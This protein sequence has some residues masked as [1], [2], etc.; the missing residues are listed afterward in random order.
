MSRGNISLDDIRELSFYIQSANRSI[1]NADRELSRSKSKSRTMMKSF[2][3][4]NED[5]T[6]ISSLETN[7]FVR[8]VITV[9]TK[10]KNSV[11]NVTSPSSNLSKATE[12]TE[13]VKK[14]KKNNQ[15][16]KKP[17]KLLY[18]KFQIPSSTAKPKK[19][20]SRN[21]YNT[22]FN[23][24]Y[25]S[26]INSN[27]TNHQKTYSSINHF[28]DKDIKE[29]KCITK[30]NITDT[31]RKEKKINFAQVMNYKGI[32]QTDNK[33]LYEMFMVLNR[34]TVPNAN[35]KELNNNEIKETHKIKLIQREW[36]KHYIRTKMINK[37]DKANTSNILLLSKMEFFNYLVNNDKNFKELIHTMNKANELYQ[38]CLKNKTFC[39]MKNVI[40]S[41]KMF[42]I[43]NTHLRI[44]KR[45]I[46][47][48][49]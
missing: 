23:N 48:K 33:E 16:K 24:T 14:I 12:E 35:I 18:E 15:M 39:D 36:R 21:L 1:E 46:V 44:N 34:L 13:Y 11:L 3:V 41:N 19:S 43:V 4:I 47:I 20:I 8:K 30:K 26:S 17:I 42:S 6:N 28:T 37:Y 27:M 29:K 49:K 31:K 25:K 10:K 22:S 9:K 7:P 2:D 5:T 32:N 45:S 38:K 40:I